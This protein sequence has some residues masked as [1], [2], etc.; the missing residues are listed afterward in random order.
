ME[1]L[2]NNLPNAYSFYDYFDY[3]RPRAPVSDIIMTSRYHV[4]L[5]WWRHK[6]GVGQWARYLHSGCWR[7]GRV[8]VWRRWCPVDQLLPVA[9]HTVRCRQSLDDLQRYATC[10]Q[11]ARASRSS[12]LHGRTH[13]TQPATKFTVLRKSSNVFHQRHHQYYFDEMEITMLPKS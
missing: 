6:D 3:V 9:E 8:L 12:D 4:T 11:L 10:C 13:H 1:I 5:I 7:S 2:A